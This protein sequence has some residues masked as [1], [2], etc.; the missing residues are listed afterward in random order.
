MDQTFRAQYLNFQILPVVGKIMLIF[1]IP[2]YF[3]RLWLS[4]NGQLKKWLGTYTVDIERYGSKKSHGK[5]NLF[6]GTSFVRCV[7]VKYRR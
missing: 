7:F 1:T 6:Q 3:L 4:F 2:K 5:Y